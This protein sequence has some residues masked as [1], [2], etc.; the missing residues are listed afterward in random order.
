MKNY[1]A[2]TEP[3]LHDARGDDKKKKIGLNTA[4]EL[5][6]IIAVI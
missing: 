5:I 2:I 4:Y 3:L 1:L 6:N